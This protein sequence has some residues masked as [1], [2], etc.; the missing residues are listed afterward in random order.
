MGTKTKLHLLL[1]LFWGSFIFA[2]LDSYD[3]KSEIKGV[4]EQW[5]TL[6]LPNSVFAKTSNDLSDIRIYNIT[7][8]DTIETPYL[9][10]VASEKKSKKQVDFKV[11][12]TLHKQNTYFFTFEIPSVET[13]NE[14]LLDFENDNFDWKVNLEASQDQSNWYKLL[15]EYRILSIKN[16]RTDYKFTSLSFPNS[17]YKYYRLSLQSEIAPE[18]IKAKINFEANIGAEYNN[19]DVLNLDIS[20]DPQ[21]KRT[22]LT[23]D[24][25]QRSPISYVKINV[26]N[27]YDYYRPI[28]VQYASDSVETEKGWRLN[29]RTIFSGILNS[30]E[31]NEFLFDTKL[32][33]KLK[34]SIQNHDNQ[35]LDIKH[36]VV[37][38]YVHTLVGRFTEKGPYYL[39][40]GNK[41]ASIPN[42]D[43]VRNLAKIPEN[44]SKL[45]L[46]EE[47]EIFKKQ[48]ETIA[49]LFENKIW[50]WLVMITII[51]VLGIFTYKMMSK[52]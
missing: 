10:K 6:E 17:N 45:I 47:E 44:P 2:Q 1:L 35:P 21:N 28:T 14:I 12:N 39:V 31:N 27:K 38:G 9:L 51:L 16:G 30:I 33:K 4:S 34:I 37:K 43:I 26:K 24:L 42:Y 7:S 36:I 49:P 50:L 19:V 52:K 11:I 8:K 46:G 15:E 13:I 25:K 41:K 23:A 5:H 32:G 20:E 40:Y 29:Y 18:L 3:S 48:G 22:V